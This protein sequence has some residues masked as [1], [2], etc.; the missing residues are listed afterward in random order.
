L[1]LLA[2][3]V[4][5][6]RPSTAEDSQFAFYHITKLPDSFR[7]CQ[8]CYP[9]IRAGVLRG[10]DQGKTDSKP[11]CYLV[12]SFPLGRTVVVGA[13]GRV[14]TAVESLGGLVSFFG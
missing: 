4:E 14:E 13:M 10:T 3:K 5:K 8:K 7:Q 9:R 1:C 2:L 12:F 11:P 6:S